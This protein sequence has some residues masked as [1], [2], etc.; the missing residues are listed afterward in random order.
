MIRWTTPIS[1]KRITY[2]TERRENKV[3]KSDDVEGIH[4]LPLWPFIICSRVK[5]TFSYSFPSNDVKQ[6]QGWSFNQATE[7]HELRTHISVQ[8][9][10]SF[11]S[12]G[13]LIGI[14]YPMA[15]IAF[16]I[17]TWQLFQQ[18]SVY[19]PV[20]TGYSVKINSNVRKILKVKVKVKF[21]L[22]QATKAHRGSRGTAVLLL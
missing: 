3:P 21:T 15:M 2:R 17:R 19:G 16:W 1:R 22:E 14:T 20:G 9:I 8:L 10:A 7:L 11:G 18:S 12:F 4:L 5:F 6:S 13:I